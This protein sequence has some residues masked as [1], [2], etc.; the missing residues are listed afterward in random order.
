MSCLLDTGI[1]L[2]LADLRDVQ[3]TIVS[4]SV[5]KLIA[6]GEELLT[7]TQNVAEFCNVA[8][9]PTVNNGLGLPP[10]EAIKLFEKDV[11]PIC[12]VVVE[13]ESGHQELNRL[14]STYAVVGKQVHDA[15]LVAMML[16]WQIE[17]ILTLNERDFRRYDPEGITIVTPDSL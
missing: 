6:Q 4:Q 3:H 14:I 13:R 5:R 9:R 8:T 1:L 12:Q 11:E 15:R 17:N 10:A 2:R 16:T 7:A